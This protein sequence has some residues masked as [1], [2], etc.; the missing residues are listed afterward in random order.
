MPA[1][2]LARSQ[3][4]ATSTREFTI[5][6]EWTSAPT[7]TWMPDTHRQSGQPRP[8]RCG[9]SPLVAVLSVMADWFVPAVSFSHS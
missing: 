9:S 3:V 5:A 4:V 6:F 7:W 2:V 8:A 1:S